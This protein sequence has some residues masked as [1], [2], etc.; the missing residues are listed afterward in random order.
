MNRTSYFA[1]LIAGILSSGCDS[2]SDSSSATS[3]NNESSPTVEPAENDTAGANFVTFESGQVRPL[4]LSSDGQSLLATNTPAG[5]LELFTINDA[6]ITAT[7]TVP[8]GLEP[9][10]VAL[11]NDSQAWV[12]NHLSDSISIVDLSQNPPRVINTLLVGDEPRDIVFAGENNRYAYVTAAHRG[13]NGQDDQPINAELYTPGAGRADVWVFDSENPGSTLGGEP[14]SVISLFGDT[15]RSLEVSNDGS[16]VYVAVMHSGNKTTAIGEIELE[17]AGPIQNAEGIQAPDTGLIVQHDGSQWLDATGSA[18]DLAGTHYGDLIPFA[19]PDMDV[20]VLDATASPQILNTYSGVGTTLFNMIVNPANDDL[21]ISNTESLNVN[22]FEGQGLISSSV[23]GDF[24]RNRISVI[25][26]G[27]VK[28]QELNTHVDRALSIADDSLRALSISQP[29]GMAIDNSANRIYVAG[30]GSNKL[31]V[32]EADAIGTDTF[33]SAA[34][35]PVS[36][37]GGGPTGIVLN[38]NTSKAYVLTRFNNSVAVINTNTLEQE[39]ELSM[40]NPEPDHV[41]AGRPFLY[42]AETTS[43]FGDVSCASCHVFGDTDGLGWDLGNPDAAVVSNPNE[44]VNTFLSTA[45]PQFHPMKGPMSTQSLRGLANAGPMHWRGDRTGTGAAESESLE[46]A[47]FKEFNE[48]FV[49]LLGN[50]SPLSDTDMTAFANFALAITYPPNPI[51]SLD[52]SLNDNEKAG[53]DLFF[54]QATTGDIFNCNTCHTLNADDN[55]FG[56]SG[57]SSIEGDDISQ[58]FKVPHFRN[59]Y[60][61]VGKFGNSGRFSPSDGL[62]GDQ[63]KG[64]GFMHDGNMDTLQNFFKGSVFRFDDNDAINEQKIQQVVEFVMA[65]DSNLAPIVGQQVT[66]NNRTAA[67]SLQR[68]NLLVDRAQLPANSRAECDLVAKGVLNNE[69]RGYLMNRDASF[70]S[71]RAGESLSLTELLEFAEQ[72]S[73]GVT[74]TCLPPGSGVWFGIDR[75]ENGVLNLDESG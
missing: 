73:S 64:F 37:N 25:A 53:E 27:T 18:T 71:D 75:D 20:F 52:N 22:R 21:L 48:A 67:D 49:A 4:A 55:H 5:T 6:G 68:L 31:F 30:F 65:S 41:V 12:V 17:K 59:L 44:F 9:V 11:R 19:L 62:F 72:D 66:L 47:A 40:F 60:Q 35:E 24:L 51:R 50:D 29:L 45:N 63:I 15:A 39:Q 33:S 14:T 1:I 23:R 57:K 58:E 13:Q 42:A 74:F 3:E 43:R 7:S 54:N 2:S 70:K 38:N 26:D 56:T 34:F 46:L 61:K 36:L 10:A 28:T 8:V 69:Q 16:K 32:Y